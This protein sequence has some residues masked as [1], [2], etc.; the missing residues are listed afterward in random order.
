MAEPM[1]PYSPAIVPRT[2]NP[3]IERFLNDELRKIAESIRQIQ[4]E[5]ERLHP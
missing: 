2:D 1:L 4:A 5:I 3:E